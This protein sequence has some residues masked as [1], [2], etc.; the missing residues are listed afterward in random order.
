M[1]AMCLHGVIHN[2]MPG[3]RNVF[4]DACVRGECSHYESVRRRAVYSRP[5]GGCQF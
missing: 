2:A 5:L 4:V 1:P 3:E